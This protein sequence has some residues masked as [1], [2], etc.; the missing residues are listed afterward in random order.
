M[1]DVRGEGL[2][3]FDGGLGR[4]RLVLPQKASSLEEYRA[5]MYAEAAEVPLDEQGHRPEGWV[6]LA[7]LLAVWGDTCKDDPSSA[8]SRIDG[9]RTRGR[10]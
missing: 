9:V 1:V 4:G 6:S 5:L 3:K 10:E 8:E 7:K 2:P